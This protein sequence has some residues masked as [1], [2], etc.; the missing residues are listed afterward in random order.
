[1]PLKIPTDHVA[2]NESGQ[3][4][5]T[6]T[7]NLSNSSDEFDRFRVEVKPDTYAHV[8]TT[9]VLI[10]AIKSP[11]ITLNNE[12]GDVPSTLC[13]L[14]GFS[15]LLDAETI[16]S[17]PKMLTDPFNTGHW[18]VLDAN[19]LK[20]CSQDCSLLTI[21]GGGSVPAK[22]CFSRGREVYGLSEV[23]AFLKAVSTSFPDVRYVSR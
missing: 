16:Q 20:L 15:S 4:R 3:R 10:G 5:F 9:P 21:C 13:S 17:Y 6:S 7:R 1:M 2:I 8:H 22:R 19:L 12:I 14:S 18:K 23:A 11:A